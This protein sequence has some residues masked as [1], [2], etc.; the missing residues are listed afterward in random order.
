M[1]NNF[2]DKEVL[3][4]VEH[5]SQYFKLGQSTLKA[6][7]DVSFDIKKGEVFGLVGE[8]GCGKTTTGRSII[9]LYNCT[10]GNVYFEGRRI[11][12]GTLTYKNAIKDAWKKFFKNFSKKNPPEDKKDFKGAFL[13]LAGVLKVEIKN[14]RSAKSDQKRCDKKY[15]KEKVGE[16]NAEYLPKLKELDKKSPEFKKLIL[17]YLGKRR[18]ARKERIVTK[19]QMVFQDPIASLDPRMTV[20]EIIAEGLKIRGIR[21]KEEIN[22]KVY[23]VLEKV[24]LVKEHAGRYPH[25]ISGGQ[26]QLVSFARTLISDPKILILDEATSSIDAKTEKEL[27]KGLQELLKGRTSF[28]IAHR[29]STIKNCD[30]IMFISNKGITEAGTHDELMAKKGDYYKLCMAQK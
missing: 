14:I 25:E 8:S 3:L 12:A 17:E 29:L 27:Q 9:K 4:K 23:E 2:N 28:I 30:K 21:N 5:L 26:R 24:G 13:E 11:C 6:V 16:V 22:E 19:I 18:F 7:N 1:S 10:D 20:R 15:A